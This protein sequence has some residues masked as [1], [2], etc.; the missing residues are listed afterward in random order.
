MKLSGILLLLASSAAN[1]AATPGSGGPPPPP[2]PAYLFS[3]PPASDSSTRIPTS[4]ESAAM[5]RRILALTPLATF[6]TVFPASQSHPEVAGIPIGMN[7]YVADCEEGGDP[8]ILSL[9]IGTSFRNVAHGSNISL[10]LAWVPP[11]PPS[12]RIKSMSWASSL[13]SFFG[14]GG[15]AEEERPDTVPYSAANLPRFSLMGYLERIE[16]AKHLSVAACY[17]NTHPDAKYWLPGNPI[18]EAEWV[19]LVV[20]KVYWVGGF[21][22]RAYIGWI[23][24]E[25]WKDVTREE[26]ESLRLPG[27]KPGWKEWSTRELADFTDLPRPRL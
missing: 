18:H 3:N 5:A 27:E 21:G 14:V 19:R 9:K 8:T 16:P 20:T 6:S 12:R 22:D 11:Y 23:P 24:V 10:A 2:N 4:R 15:S 26:W 13:L 25:E 17:V 1:A 7:D